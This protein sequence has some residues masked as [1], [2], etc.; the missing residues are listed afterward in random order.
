MADN[1]RV[2][3]TTEDVEKNA[4]EYEN[5]KPSSPLVPKSSAASEKDGVDPPSGRQMRV[6]FPRDQVIPTR[7][8]PKYY[9]RPPKRRNSCCRCLCYAIC[10]L[11]TLVAIIAITCG[12]LYLVFEPR[13]P[14]YSIDSVRIT[15]FSIN[16][17][18]STN[19]QF[20][21]NVSAR[22]PNKKV[23]IYYLDNGHLAISYSG[24]ELCTGAL[25]VFYQG[26]KNTTFLDVVL[27]RTG[28]RLTSAV[29]STLKE[30]QQKASIPLNLKADV[31]VKIKLG[32][33]KSMKIKVRVR[34]DLVVDR[35]DANAKVTT[36]KSKVSVML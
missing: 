35:L 17:D 34:W 11:F 29:V 10:F 24:T 31:P 23:G 19:C 4:G 8:I 6:Q 33:L 3:P 2:H 28:A 16:A 30:Q 26:H 27:S 13:I 18:L 7:Q 5:E 12:I 36:E 25:P 21:V 9:S 20:A 32:K 22:N 15:N 14:K 1:Q